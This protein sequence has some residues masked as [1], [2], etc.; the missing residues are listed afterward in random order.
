MSV[1]ETTDAELEQKASRPP[2]RPAAVTAVPRSFLPAIKIHFSQVYPDLIKQR[3]DPA[4][5]E[6]MAPKVRSGGQFS[7]IRLLLVNDKMRPARCREKIIPNRQAAHPT[8]WPLEPF[9]RLASPPGI[10]DAIEAWKKIGRGQKYPPTYESD[11]KFNQYP[12]LCYGVIEV[13]FDFKEE[14]DEALEVVAN[15][16]WSD[17]PLAPPEPAPG[18]MLM[19]APGTRKFGKGSGKRKLIRIEA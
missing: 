11:L 10:E 16:D 1:I 5:G 15:E 9:E 13:C 2:G 3:L 8:T 4:T 7:F 18:G 14:M 17:D 12:D 19:H 6:P